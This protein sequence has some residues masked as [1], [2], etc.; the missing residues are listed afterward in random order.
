[1]AEPA[2][3]KAVWIFVL[4]V[5]GTLG[6]LANDFAFHWGRTATLLFAGLNVV[7]LAALGTALF[8]DRVTSGE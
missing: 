4:V 6:L 1:M 7:G 2:G 8:R 5:V 3:R